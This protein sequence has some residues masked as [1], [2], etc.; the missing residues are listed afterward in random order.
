MHKIIRRVINHN[1]TFINPDTIVVGSTI[2]FD[3]Y[4]KRFGDFVII[5]ERGTLITSELA[6]RVQQN[7]KLYISVHER[8]AFASYKKLNGIEE[9]SPLTIEMITLQNIVPHI[10]SAKEK[11]DSLSN[12]LKKIELVY[13]TTALLMETI[14]HEAAE[15]LP[16]D[17]IDI[18]VNLM[19][20][21]L[22]CEE[23]NRM[24]NVLRLMPDEYSTHHHST[25]VAM[26]SIILG[27]AT[28]LRKSELIPL[29]YAALLHDIGKIRI[30]QELLLKPSALDENEYALVQ[31]H[32]EAGFEILQKNGMDNSKILEG[33]LYH[34]EKLDGKGYPA[35]LHGKRI[36]KFA[37]IIGMCDVFDALT[38]RRTYRNNYSSYEALLL[39]KEQMEHQ[40]DVHYSDTFI[41]L[42]SAS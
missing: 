18:C 2:N 12:N 32:S 41:R 20:E 5:I 3:C 35:A 42:L 22:E 33:V 17:A 13:H 10:M 37:R 34:H 23:R 24:P 21:S 11:Y 9:E 6:H 4:I 8:E 39:M 40:F 28:G 7:D 29:A 16:L 31:T 19:V 14:F 36:P 27:S 26:F 15:R 1:Y 38:T 30:D 25:N